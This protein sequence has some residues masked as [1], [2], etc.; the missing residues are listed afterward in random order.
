MRLR[1][2][3]LGLGTMGEPIANNLRKAG[4]ELTVWNRT[5]AKAGPL[6]QKGVRQAATPRACAEGRDLVLT[7]LADEAALDAVLGGPEGLL[8][9]LAAGAVLADLSTAG[10]RSARAVG[11]A[12]AARGASFLSAPLLGSRA[13]A[14]KAQLVVV[15]G[16]P[17]AARERA[18]PALR[19]ISAR[20][21]ELDD[22][23]QAALLKLCV[24]AVGGAMMAGL[25]EALAL[26]AS[27]GLPG[28]KVL[29][30]LQASTFHSPIHLMKGEQVLRQDYAPRFRLGLAEKDQRLAQEAAAD[31]GAR[32]PVNAAVRQLLGDAAASGRGE[33]DLAAVAELLLEWAKA[34]V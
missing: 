33:Q 2:G 16:G 34:R 3:F 18:R 31:Q 15:A 14:E 25:G 29:E 22:A 24:N 32:L 9:G 7:C 13:A 5:A 26:G 12:C 17:A 4:H 23:V 8:A 27:G 1:L 20:M 19:A 6:V 30:V 11:A 10:V 21:F 28:A